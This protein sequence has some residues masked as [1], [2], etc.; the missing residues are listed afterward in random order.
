MSLMDIVC[1]RCGEAFEDDGPRREHVQPDEDEEDPV[2]ALVWSWVPV[3]GSL[4][5]CEECFQ[6]LAINA[7]IELTDR[8]KADVGKHL[9]FLRENGREFVCFGRRVMFYELPADHELR[10]RTN[11]L[12]HWG[13]EVSMD[14]GA[15]AFM[16]PTLDALMTK[17]WAWCQKHPASI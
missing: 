4:S 8:L 11:G 7:S 6:A 12:A 3:D 10:V 15:G 14:N 9:N 1:Y 17:V 2:E 16:E 13:A 5:L